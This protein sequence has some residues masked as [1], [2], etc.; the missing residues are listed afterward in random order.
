MHHGTLRID[1]PMRIKF[2]DSRSYRRRQYVSGIVNELLKKWATMFERIRNGLSIAGQCWEVL[3]HDKELVLF[4]LFSSLSLWAVTAS[5]VLPL[6]DTDYVQMYVDCIHEDDAAAAQKYWNNTRDPLFYLILFGFYLSQYFV[7]TFFNVALVACALVRLNG[8]DPTAAVGLRFA[9]SR[10]S[11]ILAWS[12]F[13]AAI[14]VILRVIE[15]RSN[16]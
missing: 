11:V 13:S 15:S 4:P 7:M 3:K 14:G 1:S 9:R 10:L 12:A 6:W 8:G 2:S 5:F 16:N